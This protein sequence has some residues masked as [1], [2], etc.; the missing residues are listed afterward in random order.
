MHGP[1]LG[2]PSEQR[3]S[4]KVPSLAVDLTVFR[5]LF[6]CLGLLESFAFCFLL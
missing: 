2:L 1:F 3:L 4:E 6:R 5:S